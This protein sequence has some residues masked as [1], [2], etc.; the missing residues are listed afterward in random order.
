MS[1]T[2]FQIEL[3]NSKAVITFRSAV[4]RDKSEVYKNYDKETG[5]PAEDMIAIRCIEAI[6]GE[7]T[8]ANIDPVTLIGQ[9]NLNDFFY[10]FDIFSALNFSDMEKRE[11]AKEAAKKL[12]SGESLVGTQK[13]SAPSQPTGKSAS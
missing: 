1:T 10:Y 11:T 9:M 12:L 13:K 8:P 2:P 3:P 6:D 7:P 4:Y 5:V